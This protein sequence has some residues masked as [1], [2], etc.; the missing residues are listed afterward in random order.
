MKGEKDGVRVTVSFCYVL[1]C[2]LMFYCVSVL[3][4]GCFMGVTR[5]NLVGL[6]CLG[7]HRVNQIK[8]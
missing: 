7:P 4:L 5:L 3:V 1:R 8:N 6:S 2:L